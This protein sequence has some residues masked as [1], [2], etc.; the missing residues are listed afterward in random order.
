MIKLTL[1]Q[2]INTLR[3]HPD[4][5]TVLRSGWDGF[6]S[7][8]GSYDELAFEPASNVPVSK[9]LHVAMQALASEMHGYKGGTYRIGPGTLCNIARLGEYAETDELD[10]ER[11]DLLLSDVAQ[12]EHLFAHLATAAR[13]KASGVICTPSPSGDLVLHYDDGDYLAAVSASISPDDLTTILCV[14][15]DRYQ[16]GF[17]DGVAHMQ[18]Q[19]RELIGAAPVTPEE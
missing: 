11:L 6:N 15:N 10:A 2:V 12:A 7:W 16:A 17:H 9:M 14:A 19:L 18:A 8:R 3:N 13:A 1:N 5:A 4:K